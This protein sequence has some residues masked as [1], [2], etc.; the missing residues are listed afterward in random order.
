M[1][2]FFFFKK[3]LKPNKKM[4]SIKFVDLSCFRKTKQHNPIGITLLKDLFFL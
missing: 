2:I 4:E 3:K 1:H